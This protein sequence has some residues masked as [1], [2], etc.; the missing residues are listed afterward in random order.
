MTDQEIL[1]KYTETIENDVA[2]I[3]KGNHIEHDSFKEA[4]LHAYQK[5]FLKGFKESRAE[6]AQAIP[7]R[8][9]IEGIPLKTVSRITEL[10]MEVIQELAAEIGANFDA[11][12]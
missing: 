4:I 8:M 1:Q 9:I 6:K 3:C 12:A 7:K 2:E 11:D 5:G 10:S